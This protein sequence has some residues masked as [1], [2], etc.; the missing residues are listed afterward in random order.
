MTT[1]LL[2]R[3]DSAVV[4]FCGDSGDGIQLVGNRFSHEAVRSGNDVATFPDFPAE[5]RAPAGSTAGVSAFQLQFG[6]D[7]VYTHG[8]QADVLVAMNPAAL[9]TNFARL[10]DGGVLIVDSDAFTRKALAQAKYDDDPLKAI[11][12]SRARVIPISM[13]ALILEAMRES[14]AKR[15]DILRSRNFFALGVVY[16]MFGRDCDDIIEWINTKFVSDPLAMTINRQAFMTGYAYAE[17]LE[18]IAWKVPAAVQ[19]NS[20]PQRTITGNEALSLGLIAAARLAD[21]DLVFGCYPITPASDILHSLA[22]ERDDDI[23]TF[24][25]EDE[26][27][28]ITSAIGASYAGA[29]GV[30]ATSGPGMAL[31]SE[32]LGLAVS[33]ELPLVVINV[34]RAGPSTGMPTRTEQ[35]DLD[36]ALFGRSGEA[37]L[38]VIAPRSPADCFHA[39]IEAARIAIERMTPVIL[40]S[41]AALANGAEPWCPPD[42]AA[43]QPIR[44]G[45]AKSQLNG[46]NNNTAFHPY[47][48]DDRLVRPWAIPG[49]EGAQHCIGGL[50][51]SAID[52][53]ISYDGDNHQVMTDMRL[54]KINRIRHDVRSFDFLGHQNEKDLTARCGQLLLVSWGSTFGAVRRAVLEAINRRLAIGHLHL[55]W[56]NPLGEG[57][58]RILN[59]FEKVIVPEHNQ[60]QMTRRL[61]CEYLVDA[62]VLPLMKGRP[63]SHAEIT[64]TIRSTIG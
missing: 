7:R 13:S 54:D 58:E 28:A 15:R 26:I 34:Q 35:S 22:R 62:K 57:I 20:T 3:D 30:T 59:S 33:L 4:R 23:V 29:L 46:E 19:D 52:G 47:A 31:K 9:K 12:A 44:P 27:A 18:L 48:R 50:E 8:D 49:T 64:S 37:P 43:L 5:I 41:D 21:L 2:Q 32:A 10:K 1:A 38:P 25:A 6:T 56:L 63:F 42:L 24:Q 36:M 55:S 14:D 39:V 51:K 11:N 60:G 45:F 53:A 16:F 40:L 61:R 17:T